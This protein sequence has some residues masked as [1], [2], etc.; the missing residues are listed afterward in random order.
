[1]DAEN[2]ARAAELFGTAAMLLGPIAADAIGLAPETYGLWAGAT[3]HE[4]AQVVGAAFAL[5]DEAGHAGMVA[6]LTRVMLLAPLILT[7][8]ALKRI[9][10]N[11]PVNRDRTRARCRDFL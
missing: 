4:V 5:G 11:E 8:G 7:L 6:K 1:M 3:I 10:A 2:I 9:L